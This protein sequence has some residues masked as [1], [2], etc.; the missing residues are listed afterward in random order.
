M[1]QIPDVSLLSR[2]GTPQQRVK[3]A[4]I[5]LGQGKGVLLVDDE[6]RENEG[7]LIFAAEHL[8]VTQMALL[9]REGSGI[10]CL[11]LTDD[12]IERLQLPMMVDRNTSQHGTAFTVSIEAREGVTTGV[13]AR[14]RVTTIHAAISK[15][16][17]P[18]DL[19]R[20]GHVFPLRA[21]PGGVLSRRGHTEGTVDLMRLAGLQPA[22]VLCELTN[23]DGTMARLPQIVA[24]AD[25]HNMP[26]LTIEDLVSHRQAVAMAA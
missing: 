24:F 16:A 9:I 13:S 25:Q 10:V 21:Q 23:P 20:P 19:A 17:R 26:V 5:A 1:N 11:C 18:A 3:K 12:Q 7:D 4:L 6:D 15:N 22:G 14:D 8:T 2:F